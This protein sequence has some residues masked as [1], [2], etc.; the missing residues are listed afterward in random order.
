MTGKVRVL[1]VDDSALVRKLL[2]H[3]L[4]SHPDIEVIDVAVDA[5]DARAKIKALNPD[6][7]TLDI[8]MPGMDGLQFLQKV[9]TLRPMPVVMVST[10]TE[11]GAQASLDAIQLGAFDVFA[12]PRSDLARALEGYR[13]SLHRKVLGAASA[14]V[15]VLARRAQRYTEQLSGGSTGPT[16]EITSASALKPIIAI[17]SS[18]GG[19]EAA[20]EVLSEL[21]PNS[22]GIVITQHIP[23]TFSESFAKRLDA[24]S[25]LRVKQAEQGDRIL[26]GHAYVAPG[27]MHL[28]VRRNGAFFECELVDSEPVNRHKPSVDVLF[29]SV[30]E[31][32]GKLGIGI[33]LTGM[34][35]DGA[36]GMLNMKN[37][38][39]FTM[40][41]DEASSV[42]WGMPGAAVKL[43]AASQVT[44]LPEIATEL[45]GQL[46]GM[47]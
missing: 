32:V 4:G 35:K 43:G 14:N 25:Q 28:K 44:A 27:D 46:N 5:Q 3:L 11:K 20:A 37:H 21:P 10:L 40:A 42:V 22:P 7:M 9:M 36:E 18:T 24:C 34:G 6:V 8:E 15:S 19:T 13:D 16:L 26:T 2:T 29:D 30:A 45:V 1:V 38:G 47:R 31:H 39:A 17:G 33:I 41:Q 23:G 12:K